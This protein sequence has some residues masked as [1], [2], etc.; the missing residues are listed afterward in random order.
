[1]LREADVDFESFS[2]NH[3]GG[4]NQHVREFG[5]GRSVCLALHG[6]GEGAYVWTEFAASLRHRCRTITP[7]LRGHGDSGWDVSGVYDVRTHVAD[8]VRLIE[9]RCPD[10]IVLIGHSLGGDLAIRIAAAI[11]ER[12]K[13]ML[14]VDFGP[15]IDEASMQSAHSIFVSGFKTYR[16]VSEYA[17]L[18]QA[19]RPLARADQLEYL[20]ASALRRCDVG[21]FELKCDPSLARDDYRPESRMLWEMLG[22]T[23]CPVLVIRGA[24]SAILSAG[25]AKRMVQ[26]LKRG[27][28]AVVPAAGH[29]V[30]SDN[31]VG[32]MRAS[33]DFMSLFL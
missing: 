13:C 12:I 28:L 7:D 33:R 2:V 30:M 10:S 18:L 20:A 16:S 4:F 31:P 32:F 3:P 27:S 25:T 29:A 11:P 15:D 26:V 1:M 19:Q 22:A 6:F 9:E 24:G 21:H 14:L 23:T 5:R 17:A 8:T